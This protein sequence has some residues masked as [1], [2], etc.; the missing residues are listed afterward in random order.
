MERE[1]VESQ[2][3][4][5]VRCRGALRHQLR[6]LTPAAGP[7]ALDISHFL[8]DFHRTVSEQNIQFGTDPKPMYTDQ[9]SGAVEL[10][11]VKTPPP[12]VLIYLR[13][14]LKKCH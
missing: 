11:S 10:G 2:G 4:W 12:Y 3:R 1:N 13:V 5:P 14:P 7:H 9:I 6:V 8:R